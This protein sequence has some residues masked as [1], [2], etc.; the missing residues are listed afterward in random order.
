[1]PT[2]DPEHSR[3]R[4]G[5]SQDDDAPP[6]ATP[7]SPPRQGLCVALD[8]YEGPLDLLLTLA[9][10]Q[11]V[12]LRRLSI[13]QLAEQYLA[14][15]QSAR[16]LQIDL[17]ADYLVMAAWLAYLKSRLLLPD[18]PAD[19][20]EPAAAE[21]EALLVHRL[22]RLAAMRR[23]AAQLLERPQLG[24][25]VFA[26][27]QPDPVRTTRSFRYQ[28]DLFDLLKAYAGLRNRQIPHQVTIRKRK[29]WSVKQARTR[30]ERLLGRSLAW[31]P[32]EHYIAAYA[33]SGEE[34]RTA[35]ASSFVASLEM[36]REGTLD[37]R[38]TEAFGPLL[39]RAR[40]TGGTADD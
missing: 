28:A 4:A 11:K 23:A 2:V 18:P 39:I 8:G 9:R 26:R 30:L 10:T 38:Q 12:D 29:V 40:H 16:R 22:R 19:D 33:P 25:D 3:Q 35:L 6:H 34:R 13:L 27:G 7:V 32:L 36:A 17:A 37:L 31:A 20:D 21:L 1:M 24:R 14:F 5:D 15:I